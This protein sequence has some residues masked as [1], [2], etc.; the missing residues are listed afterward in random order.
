L[1]IGLLFSG[2]QG[3]QQSTIVLMLE[4]RPSEPCGIPSIALSD[5]IW[6]GTPG[7]FQ[8]NGL[9]AQLKEEKGQE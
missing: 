9:L 8:T 3:A 6:R 7:F 2:Q 5:N 1:F 4:F